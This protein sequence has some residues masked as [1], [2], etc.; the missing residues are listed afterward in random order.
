AKANTVEEFAQKRKAIAILNA[1]FFDPAN[2]KSTCVTFLDQRQY[3]R[4][5]C[6]GGL[7]IQKC[8]CEGWEKGK[9]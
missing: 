7:A 2:Q 9:G 1:G 6:S 8:P 5:I 3:Q 4:W